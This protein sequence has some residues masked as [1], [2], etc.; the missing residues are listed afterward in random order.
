MSMTPLRTPVGP[1]RASRSLLAFTDESNWNKG[2]F[3]AVAALSLPAN[4]H[5]ALKP[6]LQAI[7]KREGLTEL[8]WERVGRD[9]RATRAAHAIFGAVVTA[10]TRGQ[11]TLDV[12]TWDI[13]DSRHSIPG[14]D[15]AENLARMYHHLLVAVCQRW[16]AGRWTIHPDEGSPVRW[17]QLEDTVPAA[18]R[19]KGPPKKSFMQ[20]IA[21]ATSLDLRIQPLDSENEVLIQAADLAAGAVCFSRACFS[22]DT[23]ARVQGQANLFGDQSDPSKAELARWQVLVRFQDA[24]KAHRLGVSLK[25]SKGL[26]THDS[27]RPINFWWWEP[28]GPYDRAPVR[29]RLRGD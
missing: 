3:R 20:S 7:L 12:L 21:S 17:W 9:G 27:R 22:R 25:S 24:C 13:Q 23:L 1:V 2:Q 16:P 4:E 8:K 10:A 14:R 5:H 28:Q 18:Y 6:E 15:D 11:L 29:S 26:R 19:K